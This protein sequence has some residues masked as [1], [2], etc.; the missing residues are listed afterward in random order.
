MVLKCPL[1]VNV[2][3]IQIVNTGKKIPNLVNIVFEQPLR[4]TSKKEMKDDFKL[5][6]ALGNIQG[7]RSE[8]KLA[9]I[10]GSD[11]RLHAITI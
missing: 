8:L 5:L 1:F 7:S 9:Y 6:W 11:K 4:E 2:Y 3:T 10:W